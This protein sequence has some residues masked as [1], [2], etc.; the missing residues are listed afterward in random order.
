MLY[1]IPLVPRLYNRIY[2]QPDPDYQTKYITALPSERAQKLFKPRLGRTTV[3]APFAWNLL[4]AIVD[5]DFDGYMEYLDQI[6]MLIDH[7]AYNATKL[8]CHD[9]GSK[10]FRGIKPN[11]V[12]KGYHE[13]SCYQ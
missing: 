6:E 4:V 7:R 9:I 10:T 12:T 8:M 5:V 11:E 1:R 13:G 2:R 3:L